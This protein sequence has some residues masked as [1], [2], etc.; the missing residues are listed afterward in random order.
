MEA[1]EKARVAAALVRE[2]R[3]LQRRADRASRQ[4]RG[5]DRFGE[6]RASR[7]QAGRLFAEARSLVRAAEDEIVADAPVVCAT[8]TGL[9]EDSL[10]GRRFDLALVDEATQAT[11]P[12]VVP[13]LLRADR[14]VFAGDPNQ[15]PPTVIDPE[16]ARRGL[17]ASLHERWQASCGPD[18]VQMLEVQHRMHAEIMRFPS[19]MLYGGRLRAHESVAAHLLADL[20]G[21]RPGERTRVPVVFLDTAGRGWSDERPGGSESRRNPA[22]AERVAS[23][24]RA[25]VEAG[26]APADVG[27]VT[28]YAAQ[29]ALLSTLL[30]DERL[31]ID[32]VDAFQG[33]EKEAICVSL[34]RSNDE[35]EVGFP[36]DVRRM[37]V[38]LTRARRRLFV[39]GDSATAGC[40]PFCAAFAADA[41]ERGFWRSAWEEG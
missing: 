3:E 22:E 27:V 2:A 30:P 29:V 34:V 23:E 38:A 36:S 32:T 12:G 31:E 19:R 24:V 20:P 9:S 17:S 26:V 1:H 18:A 11:L 35:G 37:N 7:A 39:A 10:R 41:Q 6:A 28:P 40:H 14:A 33:R 13:A 25:L 5:A 8:L 21:V 4:G 16:A 15:L